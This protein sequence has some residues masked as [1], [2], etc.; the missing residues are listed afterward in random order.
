VC[1][2][3]NELVGCGLAYDLGPPEEAVA[4]LLVSSEM[5]KHR[6][7]FKGSVRAEQAGQHC[8]L[9]GEQQH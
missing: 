9:A 8:R 5:S 7:G 4:A 3:V 1:N 2:G 6:V